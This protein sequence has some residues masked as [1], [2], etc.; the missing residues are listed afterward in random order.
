MRFDRLTYIS[1]Y[2]SVFHTPK[3][4]NRVLFNKTKKRVYVSSAMSSACVHLFTAFQLAV[5]N[6][7][8]VPWRVP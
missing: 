1:V 7:L 2:Q 6:I 3:T 4:S 8:Y 5:Y